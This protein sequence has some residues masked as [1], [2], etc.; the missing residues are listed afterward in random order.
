MYFLQGLL[1]NRRSPATLKMYVEVIAVHHATK[2][3]F[4]LGAHKL[5][6]PFWKWQGASV[7]HDEPSMG[8]YLCAKFH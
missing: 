1:D 2:K 8:S 4:R 3:C 5:Y 7:C 6:Q